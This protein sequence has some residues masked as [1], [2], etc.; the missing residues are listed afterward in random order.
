MIYMK[1]LLCILANVC[2]DKIIIHCACNLILGIIIMNLRQCFQYG[3]IIKMMIGMD[4]FKFKMEGN[5]LMV[6]VSFNS[7]EVVFHFSHSNP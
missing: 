4:T 7:E 3:M 2:A 1:I 6:A 5:N